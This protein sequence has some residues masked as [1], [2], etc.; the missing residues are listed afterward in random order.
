MEINRV[1]AMPNSN[2]FS[3]L[4][5]K[6]LI[7]RYINPDDVVVDPFANNNKYGT[8]TNDIDTICDTT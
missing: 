1:W 5:I 3:I 6:K 4:P 8:I 2:T 7:E